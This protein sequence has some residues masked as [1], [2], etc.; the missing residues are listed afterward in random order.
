MRLKKWVKITLFLAVLTSVFVLW[1]KY[2]RKA[3]SDCIKAGNEQNWC[4]LKLK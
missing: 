4:E 1:N 2:T 3:V